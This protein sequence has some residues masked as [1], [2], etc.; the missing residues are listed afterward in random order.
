M[1]QHLRLGWAEGTE[2]GSVTATDTDVLLEA[3]NSA[4]AWLGL[5]VGKYNVT[6]NA[7]AL[8][9]RFESTTATGI[10]EKTMVKS[11][12]ISPAYNLAGRRVNA[13]HKG[14]IIVNGKKYINR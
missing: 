6:W 10:S 1:E 11:E 2:G 9:I 4:S 5:P 3:S 7:T 14:L 8:T 12:G 13:S